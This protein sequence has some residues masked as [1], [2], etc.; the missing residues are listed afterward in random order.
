MS[1]K[2]LLNLFFT[3]LL[4]KLVENLLSKV[5]VSFC[6]ETLSSRQDRFNRTKY[7]QNSNLDF[8]SYNKPAFLSFTETNETE[9]GVKP[10]FRTNTSFLSKATTCKLII[11]F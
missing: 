7:M 10:H 8:M 11:E 3:F 5:L 4:P 9:N 2:S 1:I 6:I